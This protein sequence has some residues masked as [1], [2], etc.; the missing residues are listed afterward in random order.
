MSN[1]PFIGRNDIIRAA[2]EHAGSKKKPGES[3]ED[4][5]SGAEWLLRQLD[6]VTVVDKTGRGRF[7]RKGAISPD[8]A[9]SLRLVEYAPESGT[10][11][12]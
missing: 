1:N 5:L 12:D 3:F 6:G 8:I 4:F 7:V 2:R 11:N 10:I 9:Y